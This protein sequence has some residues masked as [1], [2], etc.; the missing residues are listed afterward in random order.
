M[1]RVLVDLLF[2][3]GSKGG[4]E[5]YVREVYQRIALNTQG[6]EFV[7]I[8]SA[9]LVKS[10]DASWFPGRIVNSHVSAES[11][12]QFGFA[13]SF[14]LR[15]FASQLDADL[16][17]SPANFG[18]WSK[19]VPSI[20]TIH[21]TLSFSQPSLVPGAHGVLIRTML[22]NSARAAERILTVSN[23]SALDIEKH[24]RVAPERISVIP[25]AATPPA[26][27]DVDSVR[28]NNL[29]LVVGNN[30]PHKNFDSILEALSLIP[31]ENR[32]QVRVVGGNG[33]PFSKRVAQMKMTRWVT[34]LGWVNN[35]DLENLYARATGFILPTKFEGFGL[36]VVE[37]MLRGCPVICS[38]LQ[39]LREVAGDAVLYF[40]AAQPRDLAEKIQTVLARPKL[41][42]AMREE[43]YSRVRKFSWEYTAEQTAEVIRRSLSL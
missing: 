5:T 32:P 23:S 17:H 29:F 7:G 31:A 27:P 34:H 26:H 25:L 20:L 14:G 15:G 30:L 18:S 41:Q 16:V 13:E 11:R 9:E 10:D 42:K 19:H 12:F 33:A 39:V 1:K 24:L 38:D 40:D 35:E 28:E 36:P 43:G 21:D 3:S 8:G 6:I 37:A 2:M 4:M 22:K